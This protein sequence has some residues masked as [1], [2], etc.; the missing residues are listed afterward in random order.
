MDVQGVA[1][2]A[3]QGL[4]AKLADKDRQIANLRASLS[5]LEAKVEQFVAAR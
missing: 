2:A 1:L 3:I 4:N 5:A